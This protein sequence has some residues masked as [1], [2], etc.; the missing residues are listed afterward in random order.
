MYP[1]Q[2][3]TQ[4]NQD[5]ERFLEESRHIL[6]DITRAAASAVQGQ[7]GDVYVYIDPHS[8]Y[9]PSPCSVAQCLVLFVPVATNWVFSYYIFALLHV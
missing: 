4:L 2:A 7:V 1:Q 8:W 9:T 3:I 6:N 5:R